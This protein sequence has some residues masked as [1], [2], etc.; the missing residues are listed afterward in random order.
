MNVG[1]VLLLPVA[2]ITSHEVY[3][4]GV[5][6]HICLLELKLVFLLSSTATECSD[7]IRGG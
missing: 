7:T 3:S 5:F 2:R 6:F 4:F 1:E